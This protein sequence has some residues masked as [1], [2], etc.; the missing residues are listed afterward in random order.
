MAENVLIQVALPHLR[1]TVAPHSLRSAALSRWR[2]ESAPG[3]PTPASGT[4]G[5]VSLTL[6][7]LKA[8]SWA[9][10]TPHSVYTG[11]RVAPHRELGTP[12]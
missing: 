6:H 4:L 2:H 10:E 8:P 9:F 3:T 11:H 7:K 1:E 5:N 12:V